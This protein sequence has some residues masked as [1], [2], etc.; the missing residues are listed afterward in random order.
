M[1]ALVYGLCIVVV[2]IEC[3]VTS[4]CSPQICSQLGKHLHFVQFK[5][6]CVISPG[7]TADISNRG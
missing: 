4:E 5:L 1:P 2:R 7:L 3:S 6:H